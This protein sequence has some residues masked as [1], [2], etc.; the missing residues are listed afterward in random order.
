[1]DRRLAAVPRRNDLRARVPTLRM[2]LRARQPRAR[3]R[4]ERAHDP[5]PWVHGGRARRVRI[6]ARPLRHHPPTHRAPDADAR[7]GPRIP[8]PRVPVLRARFPQPLVLQGLR[9]V[10]LVR[11]AQRRPLHLSVW[12]PRGPRPALPA[13]RLLRR[14]APRAALVYVPP[15]EDREE[16]QPGQDAPQG[17]LLV[18]RRWARSR[19]HRLELGPGRG[20]GSGRREAQEEDRG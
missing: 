16:P 7:G 4:R 19:Y 5:R 2:L 6:R 10:S 11:R 9:A 14:H 1:M 13:L 15:P 17:G 3:E 20:Y 18:P 12:R 8:G